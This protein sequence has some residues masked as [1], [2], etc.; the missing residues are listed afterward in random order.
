MLNVIRKYQIGYKPRICMISCNF[1]YIKNSNLEKYER[2]KKVNRKS[3]LMRLVNETFVLEILTP[4]DDNNEIPTD[5]L[6]TALAKRIWRELDINGNFNEHKFN[7][8]NIKVL[9]EHGRVNYNFDENK[10]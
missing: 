2:L 7:I 9:S 3:D 10:D 1:Q 5:K 4:L 8:H 6:K